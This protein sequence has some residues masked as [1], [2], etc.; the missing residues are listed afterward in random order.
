MYMT[1]KDWLKIKHFDKNEFKHP[2]IMQK[3][4]VFLA[5]GFRSYTGLPTLINDDG[6]IGTG[7]SQ[8]FLGK[9]LDI[10]VVGL[11]VLDQYLLA[12]KY[13][14]FKGIGIYPCWNRPGLHVDDRDGAPARWLAYKS[15]DGRQLYTK[16]NSENIK[17]YVIPVI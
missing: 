9:A 8:H 12:E 10:V 14:K 17:R 1:D 3:S 7:T 13:Q 6:R 11:D 5:D 15:G 16:L 4:I 2:E